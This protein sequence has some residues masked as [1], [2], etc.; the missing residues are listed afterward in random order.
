MNKKILLIGVALLVIILSSI[1]I[2]KGSEFIN[3]EYLEDD[4]ESDS[5]SMSGSENAQPI[6]DSPKT[7]SLAEVSKHNQ[8]SDCWSIVNGKVYNLTSWIDKHPGGPERILGICGA[9]GS[10]DFNGQHSGQKKP[11]SYLYSFYIGELK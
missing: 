4:F 6:T 10:S 2:L 7:Y 8:R 5:S 11:E 1:L 9:D 3:A